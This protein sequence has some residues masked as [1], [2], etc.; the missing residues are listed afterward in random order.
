MKVII[1]LFLFFLSLTHDCS[2]TDPTP[3]Y[4]N[5]LNNV[6]VL[7]IYQSLYKN[8]L[9]LVQIN[10]MHNQPIALV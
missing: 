1:I 6:C 8:V 10:I 4:W 2:S 7:S 3:T 9:H 5:P